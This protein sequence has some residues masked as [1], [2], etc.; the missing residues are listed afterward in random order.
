M[1]KLS[2]WAKDNHYSYTGAYNLFK[3]GKLPVKATQNSQTGT[4]TV[5]D[6]PITSCKATDQRTQRS[7]VVEMDVDL[8]ASKL[9]AEDQLAILHKINE[10]VDL[11]AEK[12]GFGVLSKQWIP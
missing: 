9:S 10:L 2:Q 4:I 11:V 6:D 1:R 12:I 5:E 8:N 3:A 7:F